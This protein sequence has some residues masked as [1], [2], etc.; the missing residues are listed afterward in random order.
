M[1]RFNLY[2]DLILFKYMIFAV[3]IVGHNGFNVFSLL[4]LVL[5]TIQNVLDCSY[6]NPKS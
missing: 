2:I 1:H 3:N 6:N 5:Y 4:L